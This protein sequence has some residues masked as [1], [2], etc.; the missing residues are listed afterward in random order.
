[1]KAGLVTRECHDLQTMAHWRMDL[2]ASLQRIS[3][4]TSSGK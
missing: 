3:V 4:I 2:M 1:M